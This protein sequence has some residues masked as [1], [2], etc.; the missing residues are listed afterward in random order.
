MTLLMSCRQSTDHS[1][2]AVHE[3]WTLPTADTAQGHQALWWTAG[4]AGELAVMLVHERFLERSPCPK[5]WLGWRPKHPFTGELVIVT[6]QGERRTRVEDIRD[7]PSHLALL[8][9]SRFLLVSGRTFRG[10]TDGVWEPNAVVF[11][12]SGTPEGEFCVGDD[13]PALITDRRGGIWT[14]YGDEGVYGHHPESWAGL[15]GPISHNRIST[16]TGAGPPVLCGNVRAVAVLQARGAGAAC[17]DDAKAR[18]GR[19]PPMASSCDTAADNKYVPLGAAQHQPCTTR[20]G[21]TGIR[22]QAPY[23]Q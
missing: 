4:P 12:P 1:D 9:D 8:P 7:W 20:S 17:H 6:G 2:I 19:S 18:C 3:A 23:I 11:S 21:S 13:I 10:E 15:A 22:I 5:G 16:R 14:A